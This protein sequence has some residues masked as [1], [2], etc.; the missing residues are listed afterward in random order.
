MKLLLVLAL[1]LSTAGAFGAADYAFLEGKVGGSGSYQQKSGGF[2][3]R[4]VTD[5]VFYTNALAFGQVGPFWMADDYQADNHYSYYEYSLHY[6]YFGYA[7]A[8]ADTYFEIYE[9]DLNTSPIYDFTVNA[10]DISET[11]TGWIRYRL[12]VEADDRLHDVAD[13][14][15][16]GDRIGPRERRPGDHHGPRE[17]TEIQT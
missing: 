3:D 6:L 7:S 9:D 14:E 5:G 4:L 8:V 17:H 16:H 12:L 13:G 1:L 2:Y 10:S 15:P 11:D